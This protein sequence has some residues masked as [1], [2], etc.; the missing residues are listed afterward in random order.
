MTSTCLY[1]ISGPCGSGKTSVALRLL[2]EDPRLGYT[3]SV[4]TKRPRDEAKSV[5]HYDYVSREAFMEMVARDEFV[6]WIHPSYDEYYGTRRAPIEAALRAGRDMVFDYCPEGFL[7]LRRAYPDHVV[8]IFLMAPDLE[9]LRRRLFGRGTEGEDELEL[10]YRMA[11]Q[12][13][14]FVDV[15]DYH[16]VNEDL[17]TTLETVRAILRS[18]KARLARQRPAVDAYRELA[19]PSLLRYYDAPATSAVAVA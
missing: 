12:D 17:E 14:G 19:R 8:G 2:D 6:Q 3:R 15:H 9:T 13:F 11:L 10:R 1:V 18:E 4:T 5:E 16:V 7:N